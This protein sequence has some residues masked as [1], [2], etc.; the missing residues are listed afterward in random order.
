M[1]DFSTSEDHHAR[2]LLQV[3]EGIV[4]ESIIGSRFTGRIC[5]VTTVAGLSAIEPEITGR[6]WITGLN[7]NFVDPSSPRPEGYVVA[8][9]WGT[10][11]TTRQGP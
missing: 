7:Q 2:G 10:S 5:A 8:D 9:T 1:C 3:G 4:H 6:A 11:G